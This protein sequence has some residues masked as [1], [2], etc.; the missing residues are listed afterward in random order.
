MA[1]AGTRST[2]ETGLPATASL[3]VNGVLI[4]ALLFMS[5]GRQ[6]PHAESPAMTVMSLA[7]LKGSEGGETDERTEA[8]AQPSPQPPSP[9][10]Q[11]PAPAPAAAVTPPLPTLP[12][13]VAAALAP[14]PS[15]APAQIMSASVPTPA[16]AD[17]GAASASSPTSGSPGQTSGK[18]GAAPPPKGVAE[19]LDA[20]APAGK[21]LSY[22]AK[23]R[24]WLY[25]HKIYP[26]RARMRREE[27]IVRVRFIL[28][29]T[30]VLLDGVIVGSSGK[31]SLDEEAMSMMRRASPY[32]RAPEGIGGNRIEF[33]AP[34]EFTLPV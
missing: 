30:G 4:A 13:P 32:P 29:R 7:A 1:M 23:V 12:K 34:I 28:D 11:P 15:P 21:S 31:E 5:A 9:A 33:S 10:V 27:G 8:T 22:A 2:W 6:S 16:R 26:R 14:V 24:S 17:I 19:G 18:A 20:N 3:L 25:A